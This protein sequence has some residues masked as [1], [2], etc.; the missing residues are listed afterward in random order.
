MIIAQTEQVY[1]Q[2]QVKLFGETGWSDVGT[3][4]S[5]QFEANQKVKTVKYLWRRSK[6]RVVRVTL[7][8]IVETVNAPV[9]P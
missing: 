1:Y 8:R 5:T 6:V 9:S 2:L 3:R 4:L 7:S